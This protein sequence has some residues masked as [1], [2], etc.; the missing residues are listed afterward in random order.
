MPGFIALFAAIPF[1]LMTAKVQK[2]GAV[3]LISLI[4]GLI[5]FVTGQFTVV[6]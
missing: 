2:L 6:I 1:M 3:L 5:Y 4:T